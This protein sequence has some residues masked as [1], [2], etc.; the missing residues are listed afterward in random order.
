MIDTRIAAVHATVSVIN[1]GELPRTHTIHFGV[2]DQP[3]PRSEILERGQHRVSV[4]NRCECIGGFTDNVIE[5]IEVVAE[6]GM[7]EPRSRPNPLAPL[8]DIMDGSLDLASPGGLH[9]SPTR[10]A[11]ATMPPSIA[12]NRGPA[13]KVSDDERAITWRRRV[14]V[15]RV[16]KRHHTQRCLRR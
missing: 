12:T 3:V 4:T 5:L 1:G 16:Q 15:A 9:G 8:A 6:R 14:L 11:N 10:L 2:V 13:P 7:H